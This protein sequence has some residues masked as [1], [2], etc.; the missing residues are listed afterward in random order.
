MNKPLKR[1]PPS[2]KADLEKRLEGA[3]E[4]A[5]KAGEIGQFPWE[6][7][8]PRIKVGYALRMP[9]PLYAQVKFI[10]GN[11]PNLSIHKFILEAIE[12]KVEQELGGLLRQEK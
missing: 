9:E 10:T 11:R 2:A 1:V 8:H 3:S 4:W 12:A 6:T 5:N 7:A